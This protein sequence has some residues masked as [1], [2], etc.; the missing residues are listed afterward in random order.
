MFK[1]FSLI[2]SIVLLFLSSC[3]S[4]SANN[5]D[6]NDTENPDNSEVK[7]YQKDE[8]G[9]FILEDDYFL[10][11]EGGNHPFSNEPKTLNFFNSSSSKNVR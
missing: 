1:L 10:P 11:Y 2:C 5:Q 8:N 3:S 6:K 4:A 9:F 7:T